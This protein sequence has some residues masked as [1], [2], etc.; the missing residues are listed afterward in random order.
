MTFNDYG[1]P[2]APSDAGKIARNEGGSSRTIASR[3]VR[4]G[5]AGLSMSP[6]RQFLR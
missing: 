3:P 6:Q 2:S 1:K 5:F 4:A